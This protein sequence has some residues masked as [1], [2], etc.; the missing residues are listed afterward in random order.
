MSCRNAS[1]LC[2]HLRGRP[3]LDR[4]WTISV[5]GGIDK[6]TSFMTLAPLEPRH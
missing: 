3:H 4:R 1:S 5:V 2:R 6:M